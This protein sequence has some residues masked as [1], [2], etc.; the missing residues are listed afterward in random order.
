MYKIDKQIDK[1]DEQNKLPKYD[2]NRQTQR[3]RMTKLQIKRIKIE[4]VNENETYAT[5]KIRK[6]DKLKIG[7]LVL[8][9]SARYLLLFFTESPKQIKIETSSRKILERNIE[10]LQEI[11]NKQIPTPADPFRFFQYKTDST[12]KSDQE[13]LSMKSEIPKCFIKIVSDQG[14][15]SGVDYKANVPIYKSE[16]TD[17]AKTDENRTVDNENIALKFKK[18]LE[19]FQSLKSFKT[20]DEKSGNGN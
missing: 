2:S 20:E 5:P 9:K 7:K 13:H 15:V 16:S 12:K 19:D 4:P 1:I 3:K 14:L 18:V 11:Y 10:G 6:D 8:F 17:N